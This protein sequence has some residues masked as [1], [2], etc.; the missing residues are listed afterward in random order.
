MPTAYVKK[1]AKKKKMSISEVEER[2]N[3]AKS[4]SK[5]RTGKKNNWPYTMGIFKKMMGESVLTFEKFTQLL[6]KLDNR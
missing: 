3:K 1:L 4:L 2:W 6:Q 5:K